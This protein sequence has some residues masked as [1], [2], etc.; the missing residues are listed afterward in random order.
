MYLILA[1]QLLE[2]IC[3]YVL[4]GPSLRHLYQAR[5]ASTLVI[6]EHD[7]KALTP[8]TLNAVT[9]ANKLGGDVTALVVGSN[10]GPVCT[11]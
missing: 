3:V 9:A 5:N 2:C 4:Q 10:C 11:S 1:K 6:A 8:I 7:D